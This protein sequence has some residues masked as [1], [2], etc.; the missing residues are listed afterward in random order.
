MLTAKQQQ[1]KV[2]KPSRAS[3]H[4][5]PPCTSLSGHTDTVT[6]TEAWSFDAFKLPA[7]GCRQ[8]ERH[9]VACR[10]CTVAVVDAAMPCAFRVVAVERRW[11]RSGKQSPQ[12]PAV[13]LL[14]QLGWIGLDWLGL[15]RCEL[16]LRQHSLNGLR[17]P[18]CS[19]HTEHRQHF[20]KKSEHADFT[21][22]FMQ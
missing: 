20:A 22:L 5:D 14:R 18:V 10:V 6:V 16:A 7:R 1:R 12:K 19:V 21:R 11:P 4:L 3:A 2:A 13:I 9:P 8:I 15:G 17:S